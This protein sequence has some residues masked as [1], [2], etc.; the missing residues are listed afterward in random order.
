MYSLLNE[1]DHKE[2]KPVLKQ[3]NST[4]LLPKTFA[5]L[6]DQYPHCIRVLAVAQR[7]M[8]TEL[9]GALQIG[10][11]TPQQFV[12]HVHYILGL[13]P[14]LVETL[15]QLIFDDSHIEDATIIRPHYDV[16]F[17]YVNDHNGGGIYTLPLGSHNYNMNATPPVLIEETQLLSEWLQWAE[18]LNEQL[19][20]PR[21]WY[22]P[23]SEELMP[24][25][26][27][28]WQH[29]IWVVKKS[30]F[31][32]KIGIFNPKNNGSNSMSIN[33]AVVFMAYV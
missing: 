14:C 6:M 29:P 8:E 17:D 13:D 27:S 9:W 32:D 16:S 28:N 30:W 3:L 21:L 31:T 24:F 2:L 25:L 7:V 1:D 26:S 5:S 18:L 22:L 11:I 33:K 15:I 20:V 4:S 12:G 23:T 10:K 19:L